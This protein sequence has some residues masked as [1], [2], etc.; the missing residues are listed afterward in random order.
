M[1]RKRWAAIVLLVLLGATTLLVWS[2]TVPSSSAN[3]DVYVGIDVAYDNQTMTALID[4]V[5]AYTNLFIVGCTAIT[6]NQTRLDDTCQYLYDKG[7][8]FIVYQD[9]PVDYPTYTSSANHTVPYNSTNAP[10]PQTGSNST[11]QR[12]PANTSRPLNVLAVSNWTQTAKERWGE[13]FLGIYFMDEVAGRQL[14]SAPGWVEVRNASSCVDAA[15]QFNVSVSRSLQWMRNS[16]SNGQELKMFSSDY[17]LY[18]FDYDAGYDVMFAQFGWNYSRQLNIALCRGAA[19]VA[20]KEWGAI[21][22]WEYDQPPY[23]ESASRLYNDMVLAYNNG[24]KYIAVFDSNEAYTQSILTADQLNALKNFWQ[25]VKENPRAQSSVNN[26]VGLVLPDCYGYGFR[27]PN[28]SIWGL[29]P[30]NSY[31]TSLSSVV[32]DKL[33][34][35]GEKLDIIYNQTQFSM[36]G[37]KQLIYFEE[38]N[39]SV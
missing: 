13:K 33:I 15:S 23:L 20:N 28:D 34:E 22:T 12:P 9:A 37:Y 29:W 27:G 10:Y 36:A 6:Q 8:S 30:A 26:R 5:S 19:T 14:D 25:Y 11:G 4:Q 39:G 24:A 3:P 21:I 16:Y 1:A 18:Q 32:G 2:Q 17:A 38:P 7:L 31:S 35:Y